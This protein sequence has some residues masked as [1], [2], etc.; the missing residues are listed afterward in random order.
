MPIEENNRTL[1]FKIVIF[2]ILSAV[3]NCILVWFSGVE[4][5]RIVIESIIIPNLFIMNNSE[6]ALAMNEYF[7][8]PRLVFM[9]FSNVFFG[10]LLFIMIKDYK[11][12]I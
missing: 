8:I 11:K 5:C 4:T 12:L 7:F 3:F 9:I 6:I 10:F 2:S 1:L